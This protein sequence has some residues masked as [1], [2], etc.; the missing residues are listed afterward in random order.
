MV[1]NYNVNPSR[2]INV[3]LQLNH[4]FCFAS[5]S[6]RLHATERYYL[7]I[8]AWR[9]LLPILCNEHNDAKQE[10]LL[11]QCNEALGPRRAIELFIE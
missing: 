3:I 4:N 10:T 6:G 9:P 2:N 11:Q 8:G 7:C 1:P 5:K